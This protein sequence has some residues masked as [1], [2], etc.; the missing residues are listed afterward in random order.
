MQMTAANG[1]NRV[2][3]GRLGLTLIDILH[4]ILIYS[5]F[6]AGQALIHPTKA[7]QIFMDLNNSLT[8]NKTA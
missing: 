3:L 4:L 8:V 1:R 2:K 5:I 7:A 6:M